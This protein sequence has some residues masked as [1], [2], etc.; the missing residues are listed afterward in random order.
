MRI[1]GGYAGWWVV[2][3][4]NIPSLPDHTISLEWVKLEWIFPKKNVDVTSCELML[5]LSPLSVLYSVNSSASDL[6]PSLCKQLAAI[7]VFFHPQGCISYKIYRLRKPSMALTLAGFRKVGL[8]HSRA[9][10]LS[11]LTVTKPIGWL[12]TQNCRSGHYDAS[13]M[14]KLQQ[15]H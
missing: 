14:T 7:A 4:V 6:A 12:L 9:T 13:V 11:L 10:W 3:G 2:V 1:G 8:S 5:L 15:C